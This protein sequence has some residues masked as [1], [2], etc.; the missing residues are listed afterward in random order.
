MNH[1]TGTTTQNGMIPILTGD[2][3]TAIPTLLKTRIMFISVV[4]APGSLAKVSSQGSPVSNLRRAHRPCGLSQD[5]MMV[6]Y[7]GIF[8]EFGERNGGSDVCD[9]I[10]S[11][12]SG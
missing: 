1:K 9:T 10:F 11:S 4:P 3:K 12:N 5:C 6:V 2:R 8:D 7:L